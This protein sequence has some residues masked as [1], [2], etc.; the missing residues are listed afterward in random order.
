MKIFVSILG[1][2]MSQ[3]PGQPPITFP[4]MPITTTT[5]PVPTAVPLTERCQK[6][7]DKVN[8]F[9]N[10]PEVSS[11]TMCPNYECASCCDDEKA[12]QFFDPV[13][14]SEGMLKKHG[15]YNFE[16]CIGTTQ[17]TDKTG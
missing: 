4:P 3:D 6:N 9:H 14:N 5:A 7:K 13:K 1:L 12:S 15:F 16:G 10:R 2:A 8:F 17:S 11:G